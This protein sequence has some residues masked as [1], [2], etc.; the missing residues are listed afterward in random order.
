MN[1]RSLAF[2]LGALY[3]LLLSATF[4]LVGTGTFYGLQH[5]LRSNLRDSLSRRSTQ[6]EQILTAGARRCERQLD[7]QGNR[8]SDR[9]GIQQS[10]CACHPRAGDS[11]VSL[12]AAGESELRPVGRERCDCAEHHR[13]RGTDDRDRRR[14]AYDDSRNAR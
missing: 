9:S 14:S 5:Y 12:R 11:G 2:R 4:A 7:R 10:L 6:V 8:Y 3:T 13:D 1:Y